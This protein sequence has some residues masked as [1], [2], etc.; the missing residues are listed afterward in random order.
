MLGGCR[1]DADK[2]VEAVDWSRARTVNIRI[3]NDEFDP[4]I[5]NLTQDNPYVLRFDN[6]DPY[7]HAFRAAAFFRSVAL[8]KVVIDEREYSE[9][10]IN[11]ITVG[12]MQTAELRPR[13]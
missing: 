1:P 13:M 2:L 9:T 8:A 3:N 4:M 6:R 11:S 10:C 12:A 7:S 5:L